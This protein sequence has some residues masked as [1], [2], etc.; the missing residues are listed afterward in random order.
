MLVGVAVPWMMRPMVEALGSRGVRSA[1]VV[2]GHGAVD[3]ITLGGEC[4]V[5]A[6]RDGNISEF[7]IDA[8]DVGFDNAPLEAIRGG[9]A[10]ENADIARRILAGEPGPMRNTVVFNA[11]AALLVAG[12]ASD[13]REGRAIAETSIDSGAAVGVLERLVVASGH[14]AKRLEQ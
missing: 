11:A 12:V 3:E 6:I 14:A 5:M 10:R 2:H 7:T 4:R 8:S 9:D 13:L 1:W